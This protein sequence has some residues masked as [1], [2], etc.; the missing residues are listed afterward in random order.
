MAMSE[1]ERTTL[2]AEHELRGTATSVAAMPAA[3]ALVILGILAL[4]KIDPLLLISIAVIVAGVMLATDSVGLTQ[5]ISAALAAR[6]GQHLDASELPAGLNAGVLGGAIGVVLG[7]LAIL[8]VAPQSLIAVA[9]IVFG[10]AVLFDFAARSEARA[11]KMTTRETP[12]QAA[13]LA[14]AAASSTSTAAIFTGVGLATL[15][16]LALAGVASEVLTAAAF[17]GLGVYILLEQAAEAGH[18]LHLVGQ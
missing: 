15:G 13:R 11:L 6:A 8:D 2:A 17:T 18:L 14:L 10:A 5:Q 16:I 4:A 12:E 9:A 7:I 3:L 1:T